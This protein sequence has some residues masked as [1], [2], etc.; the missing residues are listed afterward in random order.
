MRGDESRK[1]QCGVLRHSSD[2]EPGITRKRHGSYWAYF[3]AEG[4]RVTDRD[5]ID[6]LNA[7]GLPPAYEQAWFCADPHGHLQATGVDARG[8]SNIAITRCSARSARAPSTRACLSSGR[9]CP[10]FGGGWSRISSGGN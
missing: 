10:G 2:A 8:A 1:V 3:D 4:K 6:R 5:E 7:I 9:P